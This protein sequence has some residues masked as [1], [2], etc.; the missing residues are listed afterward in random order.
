MFHF[1]ST[2]REDRDRD[3]DHIRSRNSNRE[4]K[5]PEY[6][7]RHRDRYDYRHPEDFYNRG[8]DE[9]YR[10]RERYVHII[11]KL[12]VLDENWEV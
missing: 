10:E 12:E 11:C 8:Y 6:S 3:S 5:R 2:R 4:R 9:Y 1:R 7:D